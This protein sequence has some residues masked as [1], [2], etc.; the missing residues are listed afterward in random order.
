M[1]AEYEVNSKNNNVNIFNHKQQ[2]NINEFK[3]LIMPLRWS[4]TSSLHQFIQR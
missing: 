4:K 1:I 3:L 2:P